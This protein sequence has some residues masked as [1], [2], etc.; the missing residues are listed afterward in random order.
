MNTVKTAKTKE[1]NAEKFFNGVLLTYDSLAL[2][3]LLHC[4]IKFLSKSLL[5]EISTSRLTEIITIHIIGY[6]CPAD[7]GHTWF[8]MESVCFLLLQ[9]HVFLC[10]HPNQHNFAKVRFIQ[11]NLIPIG[12]AVAVF[13][14]TASLRLK[15]NG[16]HRS[17]RFLTPFEFSYNLA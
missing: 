4:P 17:V 7:S 8:V 6:E 1:I 16:H 10:V 12:F 14:K 15:P 13:C 9:L 5:K 2:N 3:S 11:L